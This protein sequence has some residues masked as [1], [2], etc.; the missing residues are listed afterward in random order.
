MFQFIRSKTAF[1]SPE[2]FA[3]NSIGI[4][5]VILYLNHTGQKDITR[6]YFDIWKEIFQTP[7]NKKKQALQ[8]IVNKKME[9]NRNLTG[10]RINESTKEKET[11]GYNPEGERSLQPKTYFSNLYESLES[12][13][14][15]VKIIDGCFE[16]FLSVTYTD[17]DFKK[18]EFK[19]YIIHPR[20]PSAM[21]G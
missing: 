4:I 6:N 8:R 20:Q 12:C 9:E 16:N 11:L 15:H 17:P 18:V 13:T 14:D 19:D 3:S 2:I 7:N 1:V 21:T 5:Y 10:S